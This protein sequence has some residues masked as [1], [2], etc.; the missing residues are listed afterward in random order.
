MDGSR[1]TNPSSSLLIF[2]WHPKRELPSGNIS[3][4]P[5][6][7]RGEVRT[8]VSVS[9]KARSSMSFSSSDGSG[10]LSYISSSSTMTWQVEHAAEPPQAPI[11]NMSAPLPPP[12]PPK[13]SS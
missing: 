10:I 4:A 13:D 9:P 6:H 11:R 8:H 7:D 2:T 12:P 1:T 3:L 5:N